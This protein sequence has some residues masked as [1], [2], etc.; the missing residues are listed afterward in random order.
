MDEEIAMKYI[1]FNYWL[2]SLEGSD[3]TSALH[4]KATPQLPAHLPPTHPGAYLNHGNL[5]LAVANVP[6]P[7]I[8]ICRHSLR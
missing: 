3:W 5:I 4:S 7:V 8:D 2:A 1:I 6:S